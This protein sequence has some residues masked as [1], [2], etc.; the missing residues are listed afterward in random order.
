[1]AYNYFP[2]SYQPYYQP[3]QQTPQVNSYQNTQSGIL[4]VG[5]EQEAISYPVA[6][7]NAVALWDSSKPS[8]YIKQADASGKPTVKIYDLQ[9][10]TQCASAGVEKQECNYI[11]YAA[12]SDVDTLARDFEALKSEIKALKKELTKSRRK[13]VVED[14]DE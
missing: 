7:N 4:W 3:I 1:M 11:E 8:V 12:K 9:E 14:D 6:P 13:E 10:R 2:I 5:N